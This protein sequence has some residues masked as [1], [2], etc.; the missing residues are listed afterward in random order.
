MNDKWARIYL[1]AMAAYWLVFGLITIFVPSLMSLFQ[2]A[3]GVAARTAFS[4]HVWMHDGLDILAVAVLVF[5]ASQVPI[6][7]LML[8]AAGI[9][10]LLP[11]VGI[12]NSL[13]ATP[14]WNPLFIVSG[15]GCFAFAAWGFYLASRRAPEAAPSR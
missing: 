11:A 1:R 15:V 14:Y 7:R 8:A 13:I 9:A 10:A 2:T 3:E 5:A 6:N 4:D 12:A